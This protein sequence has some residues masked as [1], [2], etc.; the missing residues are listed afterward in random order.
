[1]RCELKQLLKSQIYATKVFFSSKSYIK[2]CLFNVT[3]N[4]PVLLVQAIMTYEKK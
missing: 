4:I 2:M 1:M 3:I